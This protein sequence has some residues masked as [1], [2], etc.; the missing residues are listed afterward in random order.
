MELTD[1]DL[2]KLGVDD[3]EIR[4]KLLVEAQNLPIYGDSNINL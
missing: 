4:K 2:I 1:A 3:P